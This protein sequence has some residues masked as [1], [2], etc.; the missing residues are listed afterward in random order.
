[1]MLKPTTTWNY[2]TLT[3]LTK[4]NGTVFMYGTVNMYKNGRIISAP[5]KWFKISI[6]L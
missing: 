5:T 1:M 2:P 4:I 3:L 6:C